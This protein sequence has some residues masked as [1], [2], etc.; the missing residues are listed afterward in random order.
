MKLNVDRNTRMLYNKK[1]T[2]CYSVDFIP[3]YSTYMR[4]CDCRQI[5][6]I[7]AGKVRSSQSITKWGE[8]L[9]SG[10]NFR[11]GASE[12]LI[13]LLPTSPSTSAAGR[14]RHSQMWKYW[15]SHMRVNLH[16]KQYK[17]HDS[18]NSN[19]PEGWLTTAMTTSLLTNGSGVSCKIANIPSSLLC[20]HHPSRYFVYS[21]AFNTQF[22]LQQII[23]VYSMFR[24]IR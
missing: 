7:S 5:V 24:R 6:Q 21:N 4:Q 13:H 20:T 3:I 17:Q 11:T 16:N 10:E 22:F 2:A 15:F 8:H 9:R 12:V 14:P 1:Q 18:C 19:T 23:H